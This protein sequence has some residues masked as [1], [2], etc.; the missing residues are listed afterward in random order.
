MSEQKGLKRAIG[1]KQYTLTGLAAEVPCPRPHLL[2]ILYGR[3]APAPIV[4]KR[5]PEILGVPLE[6]L[7][8]ADLLVKQYGRG[9]SIRGR[10]WAEVDS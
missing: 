9:G 2:N 8:D 6:E 10:A 1:R 4:R 5:L 3:V 7:F